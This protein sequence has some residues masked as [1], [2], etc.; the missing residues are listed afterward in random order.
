MKIKVVSLSKTHSSAFQAQEENYLKR[1]RRFC[2]VELIHVKRKAITRSAVEKATQRDFDQ[3]MR[4]IS[5]DTYL[6]ALGSKGK[7]FSSEE[8][9]RFLDERFKSGCHS[10]T[11]LIGGPLGLPEESLKRAD[12]IISLSKLTFSHEMVRLI[13]IEA[14]YRSLDILHDRRYHK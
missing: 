8:L 4:H 13:L 14:I 3:A 1:I 10:L 7:E 9:A 6:I 12:S 2:P 5:T 11:F